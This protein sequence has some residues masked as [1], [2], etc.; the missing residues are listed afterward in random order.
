[1]ATIMEVIGIDLATARQVYQDLCAEGYIEPVPEQHP[2][3]KE[4]HWFTTTKGNALANATA[5]KPI[6]RQTANQQLELFLNRVEQINTGDYAYW[7]KQVIVFGSYVSESPTLGDIDLS[8]VLEDRYQDAHSREIGHNARTAAAMEAG[9][10]FRDSMDMLMWPR[11]EVLLLLKHHSPSLS[12]HDESI[13]LVLNRHIPS[14]I[15]FDAVHPK[16]WVEK[17]ERPNL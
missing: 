15:L 7:V 16:P 4:N 9:R 3:Y 11:Q 5:R 12:L 17:K 14:R 10:R 6:T 1:M 2:L 8:L 13:E